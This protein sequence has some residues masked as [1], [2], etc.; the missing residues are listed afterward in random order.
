MQL[1]CL[2]PRQ[3]RLH[4][5]VHACIYNR[6]LLTGMLHVQVLPVR[7]CLLDNRGIGQS[8]VPRDKNLYSTRIMA[9]DVILLMVRAEA[10]SGCP[11][12]DEHDSEGH[13]C[14]PVWRQW[15]GRFQK[16]ACRCLYWQG[17]AAQGAWMGC[18]VG[19]GAA[20]K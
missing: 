2:V 13:S 4:T 8:G 11:G 5:S 6:L 19:S 7:L 16:Y 10:V 12:G 20:T 18:Q 15:S 9:D 17:A 1:T 3:A 14:S